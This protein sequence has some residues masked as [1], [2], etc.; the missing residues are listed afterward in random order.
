[1]RILVNGREQHVDKTHLSYQEIVDIADSGRAK[2]ALH[3][4]V[5]HVR[6][7]GDLHRDGCVFPGSPPLELAEDM[8]ITA[9]VTDNA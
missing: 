5:Y 7:S 4:I 8:R 2:T 6:L 1:M 3:T 9:L